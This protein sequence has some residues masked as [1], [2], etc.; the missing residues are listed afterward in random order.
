MTNV[1]AIGNDEYGSPPTA[2]YQMRLLMDMRACELGVMTTMLAE[3]PYEMA[4]EAM[5]TA[6][7]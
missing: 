7:Y 4:A 6:A 3:G 2:G 1:E 5:W